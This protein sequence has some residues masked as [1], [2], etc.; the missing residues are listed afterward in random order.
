MPPEPSTEPIATA[1]DTDDSAAA[2]ADQHSV[3]VLVVDD[4]EDT[5]DI[6]EDILE[7]AGYTVLTAST[8]EEAVALLSE[9]TPDLVLTDMRM[10]G[11]DGM[12]VLEQAKRICPDTDVIVMTGY[13]TVDLAVDCMKHGATDFVT[14]P[15]NVDHIRMIAERTVNTKALKARAAQ[16]DYYQ[17][18]ALT[19]GLTDIYN[20][21]YFMQLLETEIARSQRKTHKFVLVMLDIDDFKSFNDTNGHLAGDEALRRVAGLLSESSRASDIVARFGGEEFSLILPEMTL[22]DGK[23]AAERLRTVVADTTVPGE[24]NMVNGTLTVSVGLSEFPTDAESATLLID[25]AD[26]ALYA[27]K[28]SGKNRISTWAE[29][30]ET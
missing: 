30:K 20:K 8:G 15:F 14:K 9:H 10:P 11:H 24:E 19:D 29:I 23:L 3:H 1:P 26:R 18:L 5:R 6:L 21:R 2:K 17:S 13:A 7:D 28:F 4:D 16:T 25:R 27:A 12:D 22:D